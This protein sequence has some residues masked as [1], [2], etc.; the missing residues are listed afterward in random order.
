MLSVF[1]KISNLAMQ[2]GKAIKNGLFITADV[3]ADEAII[4]LLN[5]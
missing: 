5:T 4:K 3:F 1:E 2:K